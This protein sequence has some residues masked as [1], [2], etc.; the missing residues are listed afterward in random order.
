LKYLEYY[1]EESKIANKRENTSVLMEFVKKEIE[2]I[3]DAKLSPANKLKKKYMI[4]VANICSRMRI[5]DSQ[6]LK[7]VFERFKHRQVKF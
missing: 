1:I 7:Q 6:N 3:D 4:R 2:T 5:V